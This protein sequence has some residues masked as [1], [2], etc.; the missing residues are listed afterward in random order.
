MISKI[1]LNLIKK[2]WSR[3]DKYC[4]F[5]H[6]FGLENGAV[7]SAKTHKGNTHCN[8]IG[9]EQTFV[10]K[11]KHRVFLG[12]FYFLT[13]ATAEIYALMFV[14]YLQN[15][16][17]HLNQDSRW[18]FKMKQFPIYREDHKSLL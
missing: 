17:R 13:W 8:S 10:P 15:N 11:W 14:I 16:S 4:S 2:Q 12:Y 6:N 5:L 1:T 3:N 7:I 9:E 18:S